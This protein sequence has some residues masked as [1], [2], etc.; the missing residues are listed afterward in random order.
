M[1]GELLKCSHGD[2]AV[3]KGEEALVAGGINNNGAGYEEGDD[4]SR[5][6]AD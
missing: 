6:A 4:D 5:A 2:T 3:E 1:V